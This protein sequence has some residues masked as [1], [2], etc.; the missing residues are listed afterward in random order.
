MILVDEGGKDFTNDM[1]IEER[2]KFPDIS[3]F[4]DLVEV[5]QNSRMFGFPKR[6]LD[7]IYEFWT[8]MNDLTKSVIRM[9]K[10]LKAMGVPSEEKK[11]A[12]EYFDDLVEAIANIA[13]AMRDFANKPKEDCSW[14]QDGKP[15][16]QAIRNYDED[17]TTG[18]YEDSIVALFE[19]ISETIQQRQLDERE[20]RQRIAQHAIQELWTS[21]DYERFYYAGDVDQDSTTIDDFDTEKDEFLSTLSGDSWTEEEL[22]Q[23]KKKIS[24]LRRAVEDIDDG[25][26]AEN[27][28]ILWNAARGKGKKR[29]TA[30][31]II[32]A[33][34]EILR[35]LDNEG[36]FEW[37]PDEEAED[38]EDEEEDVGDEE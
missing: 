2:L 36:V 35:D 22:A 30:I 13:E 28:S 29:T 32:V 21:F 12:K 11:Q 17:E 23:Q 6:E 34:E 38:Y 26:Y 14:K 31:D 9:S 37:D 16:Y 25:S 3:I 33:T 15:I 10:S 5:M 1:P 8:E 4:Q 20:I 27:I 19:A 24:A 7:R 18:V